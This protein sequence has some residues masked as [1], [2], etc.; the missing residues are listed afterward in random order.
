MKFVRPDDGVVDEV[1]IERRLNGDKTAALTKAERA[2]LVRRWASTGLS[3]N[4][5]E[6]ITGVNPRRYKKEQ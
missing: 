6:R 1:A 3:N 2:E 4:A 5:C